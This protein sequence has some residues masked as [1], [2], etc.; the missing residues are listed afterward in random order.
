M[1]ACP[2]VVAGTRSG[3]SDH[4]AARAS[5]SGCVTI[6]CVSDFVSPRPLTQPTEHARANPCELAQRSNIN[7][8]QGVT[9][10]SL[11]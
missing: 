6:T 11:N 1:G 2:S 4:E 7:L 3:S 8:R 9:I 5:E 10:H